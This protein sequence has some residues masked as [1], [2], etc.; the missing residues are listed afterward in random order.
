MLL[1]LQRDY[2][3]TFQHNICHRDLKLEN[4]LLDEDGC[5]KIADFG[6]S[7]VFLHHRFSAYGLNVLTYYRL[8]EEEQR[9]MKNPMCETF[10][11]IGK[12][13]LT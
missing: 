11:R 10:P 1:C 9:E 6:L 8:P 13:R 2:N 5:A 3:S 4:I 12:L 7:N